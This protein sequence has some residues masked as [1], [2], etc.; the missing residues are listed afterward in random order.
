MYSFYF[1]YIRR[2]NYLKSV[3]AHLSQTDFRLASLMYLQ[4]KKQFQH[5]YEHVCKSSKMYRY[6][7]FKTFC[8][9]FDFVSFSSSSLY[10]FIFIFSLK[11]PVFLLYL[12]LQFR[13][14]SRSEIVY[15]FSHVFVIIL[16]QF[17]TNTITR[18]FFVLLTFVSRISIEVSHVRPSS[19]A[20]RNVCSVN[21][22]YRVCS[23]IHVTEN[24]IIIIFEL[25]YYGVP[26]G[27][28][29]L[30]STSSR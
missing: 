20:Y 11:A 30:S 22:S 29:F 2:E 4:K 28:L 6:M 1:V 14:G 12:I 13:S 5:I 24:H 15:I 26:S 3:R 7:M 17:D 23:Q 10:N 21:L 27:R 19:C 16:G 8:I 9:F 18:L 25:F